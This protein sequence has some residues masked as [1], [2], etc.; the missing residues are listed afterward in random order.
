MI[1]NCFL[2]LIFIDLLCFLIL[3]SNIDELEEY[4]FSERVF[5]Q[6]HSE[7]QKFL[8]ISKEAFEELLEEFSGSSTMLMIS[9]KE[10]LLLVFVFLKYSLP[11]QFLGLLFRV[12]RSTAQNYR[13]SGMDKLYYKLRKEI[14]LKDFE[15]RKKHGFH[16]L[17]SWYTVVIDGSEQKCSA[18]INPMMNVEFFSAK[19]NQP[20]INILVAA[21][22][23]GN[24]VLWVSD[25]MAGM[26]DDEACVKKIAEAEADGKLPYFSKL[27][28]NEV[29]LSDSGFR[30]L[31]DCGRIFAVNTRNSDP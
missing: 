8:G 13:H 6:Q 18:S 27:E 1:R 21:S 15:W 30:N 2:Q 29:V 7:F 19:K 11:D 22:P 4:S 17:N 25:S 9:P 10:H 5:S 20:S 24:R 31:W 26:N 3:F 16:Y 28:E 23:F 12:S 14:S